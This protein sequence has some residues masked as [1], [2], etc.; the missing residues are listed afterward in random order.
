M[1]YV[2]GRNNGAGENRDDNPSHLI[3]CML[4]YGHGPQLARR[5][6]RSV[7]PTFPFSSR[8]HG[9]GGPE[10]SWS[11]AAARTI[12]SATMITVSTVARYCQSDICPF[13][14][15]PAP[16][17]LRNALKAIVAGDIAEAVDVRPKHRRGRARGNTNQGGYRSSHVFGTGVLPVTSNAPGRT[18]TRD[19]RFRS[20]QQPS[21]RPYQRGRISP[22]PTSDPLERDEG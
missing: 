19:L 12:P 18:R 3:T 2:I 21:S 8:S 16:N 13:D 4:L 17:R 15:A 14:V 11:R 9:Q 10:Q 6:R 1:R 22:N 7:A 20:P 5:A